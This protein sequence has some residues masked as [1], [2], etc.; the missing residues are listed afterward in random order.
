MMVQMKIP[1]ETKAIERY[2]FAEYLQKEREKKKFNLTTHR[3]SLMETSSG[4]KLLEEVPP[5][6]F[7]DDYSQDHVSDQ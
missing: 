2:L 6:F 1:N 5:P 4:L 3:L 7:Q